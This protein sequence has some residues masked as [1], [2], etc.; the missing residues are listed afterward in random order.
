MISYLA[1]E[2]M[3]KLFKAHK[4]ISVSINFKEVLLQTS[5]CSVKFSLLFNITF[6]CINVGEAIFE[7]VVHWVASLQS[8]VGHVAWAHRSA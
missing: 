1:R 2:E 7:Y 3:L 5:K 4:S 6:R 8:R